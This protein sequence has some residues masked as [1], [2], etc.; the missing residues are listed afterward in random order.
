MIEVTKMEIIIV[1]IHE[2]TAYIL[3]ALGAFWVWQWQ[4][5]GML[6]PVVLLWIVGEY[7]TFKIVKREREDS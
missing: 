4:G 6:I 3:M 5:L 2:F 1:T 7:T